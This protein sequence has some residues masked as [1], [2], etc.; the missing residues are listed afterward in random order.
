MT[1]CEKL[2]LSDSLSLTGPDHRTTT[3]RGVTP[4]PKEHVPAAPP[5]NEP[6]GQSGLVR[7]Q[8]AHQ[9]GNN[10]SP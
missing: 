5:K 3:P 4:R 1:G 7:V 6:D 2:N 9:L 8:T 10:G